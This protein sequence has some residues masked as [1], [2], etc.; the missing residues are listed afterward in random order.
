GTRHPA[1]AHGFKC[2]PARC[3]RGH[4]C[5][6][7]PVKMPGRD[8]ALMHQPSDLALV[9][10][11]ALAHEGTE[12]LGFA[13]QA[14]GLE[15]LNPR[16]VG[17]DGA[18]LR[19]WTWGVLEVVLC[20]FHRIAAFAT[21]EQRLDTARPRLTS[22]PRWQRQALA[23]AMPFLVFGHVGSPARPPCLRGGPLWGG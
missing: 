2:A 12:R 7:Q 8:F 3:T 6:E 16:C 5:R 9:G 19:V 20:C 23:W 10:G 18:G 15:R 4:K 1:G 21:R 13:V 17:F 14:T 22:R 11:K